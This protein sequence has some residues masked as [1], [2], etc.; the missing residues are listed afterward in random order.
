MG[1]RF[2]YYT[3]ASTALQVIRHREIWMRNTMVMNDF[4]EVD[5]GVACVVEAYCGDPGVA[6]K[7]LLEAEYPDICQEIENLFDS[8][9]PSFR[10]D[11]FVTCFSEHSRDDDHYGRLSMWRA[12][13]G[14]AG[15]ALVVNGDVFFSRSEVLPAYSS[16]VSYLDVASY[17]F[18]LS[19]IADRI[20]KRR[21]LLQALGREGTR[22]TIFHVLRFAAICTKHPAF[23]EEREWRV[24][25]SPS[26]HASP[27]LPLAI[28]SIGGIPQRVL[29]IKLEDHP[30]QGLVGL[31][32]HALLDRLLIGPCE[33]SEA[34]WQALAQALREAG[35]PNAEKRIVRTGIPLRPDQ[36]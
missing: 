3:T 11:T 23:A 4:S 15:V 26:L 32:P 2:A 8:W 30:D 27:L 7:Q 19:E 10:Q 16:P 18:Q 31:E 22:D 14:T 1:T 21:E 6:L 17:G 12:Y 20:S 33:H 35:I 25:S 36:R 28:E 29:K 9:V 5:H 34:V 24:V 13:G